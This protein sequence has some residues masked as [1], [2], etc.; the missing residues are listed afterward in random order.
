MQTSL[1]ISGVQVRFIPQHR[2]TPGTLLSDSSQARRP[3]SICPHCREV[4]RPGKSTGTERRRV[5]AGDLQA[6]WAV[7]AS[8]DGV[9][10]WGDG[11]V[12]EL[13]IGDSCLTSCMY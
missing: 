12:L 11:N 2:R 8:G 5:V 7:P 3:H 9:S 4:S 6:E 10:F 1:F 13:G